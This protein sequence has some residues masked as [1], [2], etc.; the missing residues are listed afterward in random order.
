MLTPL[1]SYILGFILAL[2]TRGSVNVYISSPQASVVIGCFL[3]VRDRPFVVYYLCE[4]P[5]ETAIISVSI[6]SFVAYIRSHVVV[7]WISKVKDFINGQI[8]P[9][10][11]DRSF[12]YFFLGL[13]I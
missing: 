11:S 2:R 6:P 12:Y 13:F 5:V 3:F 1:Y 4:L 8:I 7:G 9:S 10:C